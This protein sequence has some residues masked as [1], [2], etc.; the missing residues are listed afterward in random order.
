MNVNYNNIPQEMKNRKQWVVR[1]GK[2]PIN[3]LTLSGASS[4]NPEHWTSFED[5]LKAQ[6]KTAKWYDGKSKQQAGGVVDGIGF[7]LAPPYCGI[8]LDHVINTDTGEITPEASDVVNTMHSYTE[9]SPSGTGLHIIYKGKVHK[10]RKNKKHLSGDTVIEMYQQGRYFTVTGNRFNDISTVEEGEAAA[11]TVYNCYLGGEDEKPKTE[12]KRPSM[13]PLNLSAPLTSVQL[14][15]Q[16]IINKASGAKNGSV[17]SALWSGDISAYN[18]DR[19]SADM[20]LCNNLAFYTSDAG[21]IDRIFRNSKLMREKW[22]RKTGNTTY[23][24]MT[25]NKALESVTQHYN[26]HRRCEVVMQDFQSN[27]AC[28]TTSE[29]ENE[30]AECLSYDMIKRYKANYMKAAELF[31]SCVNFK[32]CYVPECK[33]FFVYNGRYWK[34][35][36]K[37][38]ALETNRLLMQFVE[39]AQALIPPKPPGEPKDWSEEE[40]KQ[41]R[42]NSAY[43]DLYKHLTYRGAREQVLKD[44]RSHLK[45]PLCLFDKDPYLLNLENGTYNLATGELKPHRREDLITMCANVE[46]NPTVKSLRFDR[47]IDEI[48]QGNKDRA[49]ALQRSLGYSLKGEAN[50]ECFFIALGRTTRN[51]KGTLFDTVKNLLGGYASQIDFATIART[52]SKDGSRATPDVARLNGKRLVLANEPDKGSC[53]NE[54]LLKQLTGN[55]DIAA[56]QLYGDIFEFKP[57]FTLFISANDMPAIADSSVF[58]SDRVKILPFDRHFTEKERDTSLKAQLRGENA[59]SAILNWLIEGYKKYKQSGLLVTEEMKQLVNSYEEL[60]DTVTTFINERLTLDNT[61]ANVTRFSTVVNEYGIWCRNMNIH[62]PLGRNSLRQELE[63]RGVRLKCIH[64]QWYICGEIKPYS[65]D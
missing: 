45:K 14:S 23:G 63:R 17:F 38:D 16:D 9:V 27:T 15:D 13:R 26:P 7:V 49:E 22:D 42:V 60:N 19:S 10:E 32:V 25:I 28:E 55:D 58:K 61:C 62:R 51:G 46:Y 35:D 37:K 44:C 59:K 8:D 34:P 21:Q 57:V 6:G 3:A 24:A 41:E 33:E 11:Q 18:N 52:G 5:A 4:T 50:E 64:K 20:A 1:C 65:A 2:I 54:A 39:A 36:D 47:F 48:T 30:I 53:F 29:K 43:R 31:A 40:A 56:R 12:Q